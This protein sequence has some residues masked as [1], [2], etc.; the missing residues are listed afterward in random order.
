MT[1][2]SQ[3]PAFLTRRH[4][5][6]V[7]AAGLAAA[8]HAS[9]SAASDTLHIE[10]AA[11][12]KAIAGEQAT[13]LMLIPNGSAA[14]VSPV[15][16][17][18]RDL[19]GVDVLTREVPVDEINAQLTLDGLS[20]EADYDLA[21]PA[22]FGIPDLVDAGVIRPLTEYARRHEPHRFRDD[23]LYSI[24]DTFDGEIYGFQADGDTYVM[25]YNNMWMSDP[26]QQAKYADRFGK[27]LD[28]P[29]TWEDLD[30][31][32]AFFHRPDED[33]FGGALFRTPAYLAWEWWVRF[34]AKGVW[35]F[36]QDLEPQVA[37][38]AGLSALEDMIKATD[39]LYPQA[40]AAG[41]F[42]NWE[43]YAHGNIYANIGWGGSQ[44][45][46]NGPNSKMRGNMRFGM[47]PTSKEHTAFSG[48]PYFNWGWN[49]VVSTMCKQP[50]LSYLLGLFA[51]TPHVSTISVRQQGGYFDPFR[52]EHY[53]DPEI[54]KIYTP[55]FLEVHGKSLQSSIPDLYLAQQGEYF[56]VLIDALDAAVNGNA[57]PESA[58]K[59]VET[60]WSILN[61][62]AGRD[63]Q[64][65]RWIALREK[66][67][68]A[69]QNFLRDLD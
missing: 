15:A 67:P 66:Y 27:A 34:H 3:N 48:M 52:P 62:R 46:L 39:S 4:M 13:L 7:T 38:D 37:S 21:L 29:Q 65:K 54:R 58:L 20:G 36:S 60:Q 64:K 68:K 41:L 31:Q 26:D 59:R 25:F 10:V 19:T 14:N 6:G 8:P 28:I 35:P 42:E 47:I 53:Q 69:A 32:M 44:K 5:I 56:R 49:Y 17:M 50:E 9:Y 2:S 51:S 57:K 1:S 12:A 23:I 33:K 24:G 45:Y 40:R 11:K 18:F 30:Q 63:A 43:H 55:E 22:T 61:L 16:K